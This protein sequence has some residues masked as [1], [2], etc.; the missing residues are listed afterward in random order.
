MDKG[1]YEFVLDRACVQF[2]PDD[3]EYIRVTRTAYNCV[4][5]KRDYA[6]LRSTRHFGPLALHL[7][8]CKR[9]D[10]LL[11]HFIVSED[12]GAAAD[13]VKLFHACH[14]LEETVDQDNSIGLIEVI[15]LNCI[16]HF[17]HTNNPFYLSIY[18]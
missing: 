10:D 14:S 18:I 6:A 3:P 1:E 7:I 8:L 15:S 2:E 11:C 12:I 17:T 13:L 16:S 4:D 9:A 5:E